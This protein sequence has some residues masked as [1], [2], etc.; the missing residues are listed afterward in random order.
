MSA[1]VKY[2]PVSKIRK[3]TDLET[4]V[5]LVEVDNIKF[6][7][8]MDYIPSLSQY[9]RGYYMPYDSDVLTEL[10]SALVAVVEGD[11]KI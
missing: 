11:V 5:R 7:E 10:I 6:L 2:V 9:G 3:Q 1:S 4:H 8:L